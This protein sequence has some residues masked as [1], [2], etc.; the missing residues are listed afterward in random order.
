MGG[1][2]VVRDENPAAT[3]CFVVHAVGPG[4]GV[5]GLLDI[6]NGLNRKRFRP[7]VALLSGNTE[8]AES[9]AQ[10]GAEVRFWSHVGTIPH[11]T[12]GW[13]S[14][15]TPWGLLGLLRCVL[16]LPAWVLRSWALVRRTGARVIH[17]NSIVLLPV[18][19]GARLA[20]CRVVW[21]VRESVH[22]GYFGFRRSLLSAAAI[23]LASE[24]IFVCEDNRQALGAGEHG[25]VVRES[26]AWLEGTDLP[27]KNDARKESGWVTTDAV[28]LFL[29]GFGHLKGS[30]VLVRAFD[31]VLQRCPTALLVMAGAKSD[32]S[33]G[34]IPRLARAVLPA[35]G[36]QTPRQEFELEIVRSKAARRIVLLPFCRD[37]KT[38]LAACDVVVCPWSEP[39]FARPAMEAALAGRPSVGSAIGGVRAAIADGITGFLVKPC[40]PEA[41]A[42]GICAVLFLPDKG[43]AMGRA[44]R[45]WAAPLFNAN[46][47]VKAIEGI[48]ARVLGPR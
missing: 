47:Q 44:A 29:G 9:F 19:L 34:P 45:E 30:T 37:V 40:D 13:F 31:L 16:F 39:H 24:L 15:F 5:V 11:T 27:S 32:P 35:F 26:A 36:F 38:L 22:P 41:L 25:I 7:V 2:L 3:I 18:V 10:A 17:A 28:V 4:G 42:A 21:H 43:T 48:Y 23:G 1:R 6:V 14:P 33:R 12:G 20:G 8:V 46:E